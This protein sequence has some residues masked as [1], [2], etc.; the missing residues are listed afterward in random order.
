MWFCCQLWHCTC[1]GQF[2]VWKAWSQVVHP[3]KAA[4]PTSPTKFADS[5]SSDDVRPN[6]YLEGDDG[7]DQSCA[8]PSTSSFEITA[9]V[10]KAL[11]VVNESPRSSGGCMALPTVSRSDSPLSGSSHPGRAMS[12]NSSSSFGEGLDSE[13]AGDHGYEETL[14]VESRTERTELESRLHYWNR[15]H[16]V[17]AREY[18]EETDESS[19]CPDFGSREEVNTDKCVES[20][21]EEKGDETG[22]EKE[23]IKP[24]Y[25]KIWELRAT[26]EEDEELEHLVS[27]L[28]KPL[29]LYNPSP[30]Q[31]PETETAYEHDDTL[32]RCRSSFSCWPSRASVPPLRLN[33]RPQHRGNQA[34]PAEPDSEP[35]GA[36]ELQASGNIEK[37][38]AA[39]ATVEES[40]ACALHQLRA[41]SACRSMDYSPVSNFSLSY[42]RTE[43][44]HGADESS[45]QAG[46]G[47]PLVGDDDKEK[48]FVSSDTYEDTVVPVTSEC[49][50]MASRR[51]PDNDGSKSAPSP[52]EVVEDQ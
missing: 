52:S 8:S 17:C 48:G 45:S 16:N 4:T 40:Q 35:Q 15:E 39:T 50:A 3:T 20:S 28:P 26:L 31:S 7:E 44:S 37:E 1:L 5:G 2:D 29:N 11:D 21:E 43:G 32:P 22:E 6:V 9:T 10:S 14:S 47:L 12:R 13:A 38:L 34:S 24:Q 23:V 42:F 51:G 41:E 46:Q 19:R 18:E 30:V 36:F 27:P 25:R 33:R 49:G